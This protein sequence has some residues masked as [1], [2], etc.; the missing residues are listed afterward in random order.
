[1]IGREF[2]LAFQNARREED[3][4]VHQERVVARARVG[5][6]DDARGVVEPQNL[7]DLLV[8]DAPLRDVH[9]DRA[10]ED[11]VL[12][13]GRGAGD[14]DD[15]A[16]VAPVVPPQAV[17]QNLQIAPPRAVEIAV[18]DDEHVAPRL[19]DAAMVRQGV[20]P[21]SARPSALCFRTAFA[22]SRTTARAASFALSAHRF[23]VFSLTGCNALLRNRLGWNRWIAANASPKS[24]A[25][26]L[27]HVA[28]CLA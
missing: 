13:R 7:G 21:S 17:Q 28:S 25:S 26:D 9:L 3:A 14:D 11:Q 15:R 12:D 5:E 16:H 22:A 8:A 10:P 6:E 4:A 1:M 23:R 20:K 19:G 27:R 24:R 2:V 18:D